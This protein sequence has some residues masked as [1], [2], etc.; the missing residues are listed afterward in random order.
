MSEISEER[1]ICSNCAKEISRKDFE[2]YEGMCI[3]CYTEYYQQYDDYFEE[4]F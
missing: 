1:F 3:D 2:E 4:E